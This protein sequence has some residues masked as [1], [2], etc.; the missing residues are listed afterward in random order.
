MKSMSSHLFVAMTTS[1]AKSKIRFVWPCTKV[2]TAAKPTKD[3]KGRQLGP[4][5][6]IDYAVRGSIVNMVRGV[7]AK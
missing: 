3:A 7:G 4:S 5:K 2:S 6:P 1:G